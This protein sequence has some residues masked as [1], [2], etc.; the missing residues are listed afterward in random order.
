MKLLI[1]HFLQIIFPTIFLDLCKKSKLTP[2]PT[3]WSQSSFR[4][5][6]TEQGLYAQVIM[7]LWKDSYNKNEKEKTNNITPKG[8]PHDQDVG[9]ILIISD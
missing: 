6:S 1:L 3:I 8:N 4:K 5:I 9:L 7:I 2:V